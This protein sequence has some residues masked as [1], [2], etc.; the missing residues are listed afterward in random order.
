[1]ATVIVPDKY[2][3]AVWH[4]IYAECADRDEFNEFYYENRDEILDYIKWGWQNHMRAKD[5][6]ETVMDELYFG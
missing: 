2:F 5:V 4:N 1:M 6:A 3:N